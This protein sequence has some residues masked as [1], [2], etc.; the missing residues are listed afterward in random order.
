MFKVASFSTRRSVLFRR[1]W[2]ARNSGTKNGFETGDKPT[3]DKLIP[4]LPSTLQADATSLSIALKNAFAVIDEATLYNSD[5]QDR[6][7]A[8]VATRLALSLY[9]RLTLRASTVTSESSSSPSIGSSIASA[10]CAQEPP[11][12]PPSSLPSKSSSIQS[13]S[14]S[15]SLSP[16]SSESP[17]D[18]LTASLPTSQSDGSLG[19]NYYRVPSRDDAKADHI[20]NSPNPVIR[21]F[22]PHIA[23]LK[24]NLYY[25]HRQRV[26]IGWQGWF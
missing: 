5:S 17:P 22:G 19:T 7:D 8:V 21:F 24:Y 6:E 2:T 10:S 23:D 1:F 26:W 9:T 25:S 20:V 3:L 15:F 14:A 11:A 4:T 18:Q 12:P 16:P 13:T